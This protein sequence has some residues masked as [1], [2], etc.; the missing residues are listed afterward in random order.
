MHRG[1]RTATISLSEDVTDMCVI[2]LKKSKITHALLVGL[3][4]GEVRMYQGSTLLYSFTVEK[5]VISLRFGF[6]GREVS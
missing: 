4:N 1:K 3:A 6:Y 2:A 5:P